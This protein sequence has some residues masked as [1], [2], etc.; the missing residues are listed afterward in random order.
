MKYNELKNLKVEDLAKQSDELKAELFMLRLKNKT[1]QLENKAKIR[2]VRRDI[3]RIQTKI[4]EINNQG[5]AS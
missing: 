2:L 3:A 4:S 5:S 1:A